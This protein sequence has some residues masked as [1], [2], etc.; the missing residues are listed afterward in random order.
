MNKFDF[1]LVWWE[2]VGKAMSDFP[3][4]FHKFVTKQVSK[5]CG[6]NRQLSCIDPSVKNVCPSC[7]QNDE[8]SKHKTCCKDPD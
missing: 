3:D 5:F 7:G 8:S 6:T 1:V 2:G 4:D